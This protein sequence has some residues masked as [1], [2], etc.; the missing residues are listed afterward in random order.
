MKK[1]LFC[2][3]AFLY[4]FLA[5]CS[6]DADDEQSYANI[7]GTSSNDDDEQSYSD[8]VGTWELVAYCVPCFDDEV[9]E[10]PEAERDLFMFG[11]DRKVKV[12]KKMKPRYFP[13]FPNEDGVYD[14][15]YN[16][17]KQEIHFFGIERDCII[18]DDEMRMEGNHSDHDGV[19]VFWYIFIKK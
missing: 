9:F 19:E 3:S 6:N 10:L 16:K 12:I 17:E 4:L 7:V 1:I 18:M 11:S 2:M 5:G 8:I 14:Y 13:L 15:S